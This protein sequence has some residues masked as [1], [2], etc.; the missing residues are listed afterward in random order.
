MSSDNDL[1]STVNVQSLIEGGKN[2][3]TV[4]CIQCPSKIL[5]KGAGHYKEIEFSLPN[6]G[7]R[8][9]GSEGVVDKEVLKDYWQ[10]DNIYDFENI[11]Y[12]NTVDG[13][14]YLIC[15]D[16]EVGPL[17]WQNLETKAS[18]LAVARVKYGD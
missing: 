2:K 14:K 4:F 12:S 15:A 9:I 18:Y 5:C 8:K 11:G 10:V 7:P 13:H 1:N 6:A 3:Q 17:G 16:C